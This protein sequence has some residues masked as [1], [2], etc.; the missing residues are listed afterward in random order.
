MFRVE[1]LL[2]CGQPKIFVQPAVTG[3]LVL[4]QQLVVVLSWRRLGGLEVRADIDHGVGVWRQ[5]PATSRINGIGGRRLVV[6]ETPTGGERRVGASVEEPMGWNRR[7]YIACDI[8]LAACGVGI[9]DMQK[10]R[11]FRASG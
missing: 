8:C 4:V 9:S 7:V 11:S 3:N 1:D 2:E 10:C 6:D 5:E